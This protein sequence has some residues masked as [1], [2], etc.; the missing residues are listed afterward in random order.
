MSETLKPVI[1]DG[2]VEIVDGMGIFAGYDPTPEQIVEVATADALDQLA[3]VSLVRKTDAFYN[4]TYSLGA[5]DVLD[6]YGALKTKRYSD[7]AVLKGKV[8]P[9]TW[10]EIQYWANGA[11]NTRNYTEEQGGIDE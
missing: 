11:R 1:K 10:P 6:L 9:R 3:L 5:G 7:I 2:H 8:I 4:A